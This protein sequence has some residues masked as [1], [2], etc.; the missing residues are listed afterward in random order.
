MRHAGTPQVKRLVAVLLGVALVGSTA[1]VAARRG[2]APLVAREVAAPAIKTAELWYQQAPAP[3]VWAELK[4]ILDNPLKLGATKT[5]LV[6]SGTLLD[7]FRIR[8]TD[9]KLLMPPRRLVDGRVALLFPAPLDQSLNWYR[10]ELAART[11]APRPLI[12]EMTIIGP[13]TMPP[14][15]PATPVVQFADRAADPFL[16]V[17][18]PLIGAIPGR[19][20]EA[21]PVLVVFDVVMGVLAAMGCVVAFRLAHRPP[22]AP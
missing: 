1:V 16:A 5:Q 2:I 8:D 20:R 4:V 7:D 17:P 14:V 21:F 13:G 18:R 3:G 10:L 6:V 12:V 11:A 9:P 22:P 19:A 15:R